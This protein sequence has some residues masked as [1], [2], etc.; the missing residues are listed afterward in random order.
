MIT[1]K[2]L[3]LLSARNVGDIGMRAEKN[4]TK[5]FTGAQPRHC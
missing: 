1:R 2:A 4:E 3:R 5:R